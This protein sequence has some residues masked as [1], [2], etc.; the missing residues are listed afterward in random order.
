VALRKYFAVD[1]SV[2]ESPE[3]VVAG[4]NQAGYWFAPLGY[5]SHPY[6]ADSTKTVAPGDFSQTHVGDDSDTSPYPDPDLNGISLESF[7]RNMSVLVRA[8]DQAQ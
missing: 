3:S 7:V 5:N 6:K 1:M 8:L 2:N 4:L